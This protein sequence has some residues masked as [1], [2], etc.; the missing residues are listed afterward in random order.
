MAE[1]VSYEIDLRQPAG[2]RIQNLRFRDAPLAD[3]QPLTLAINN[4]RAGGSGGYDMFKNAKVLW[5]SNEA[6]RDLLIE[7]YTRKKQF[8][9]A[10]SGNW[11]LLPEAARARLIQDAQET[12]R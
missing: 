7:Y 6:I 10:A 1:G 2:R 9:T 8:P 11:K 3:N 12:V 5:Q 4:Y